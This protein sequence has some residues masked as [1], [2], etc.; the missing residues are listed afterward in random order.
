MQKILTKIYNKITNHAENV[1]YPYSTYG[2]LQLISNPIFYLTWLY[3]DKQGYES[4]PIRL[5]ISLF[6]IPLVFKEKW[7]KKFKRFIPL[8]W[9]IYALYSLPFFF[10]FMLLKNDLS[11]GWSLNSLTGVILTILLL[12]LISS[13][14]LV[15]LGI[16]L[17]LVAYYFTTENPFSVHADYTTVLITY[18]TVFIFGVLFAHKK[19]RLQ[20]AKL[21]ATKSIGASFAHEIRTP[22]AAIVMAAEAIKEYWS[23]ITEGY[24]LAK[25]H[26]LP[27]Q[28]LRDSQLNDLSTFVEDI[29]AETNY[30][31][32]IINMLL[33]KSNESALDSSELSLGSMQACVDESLRR[34]PFAPGE[35]DLV[36]WDDKSN[37]TFKGN[38]LFMTHVLFNLLKNAI[39]Y[40]RA[41]GKGNIHIWLEESRTVNKLYF[42]DTGTG[43]PPKYM[44]HLFNK[45]FTKTHGGTGLGL[46]FS[47]MVMQSFGGD[48]ICRSVEGEYT[49]FELSFPK[50]E[51]SL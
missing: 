34:Y 23:S 14:I 19:E 45:F 24:K 11:Y 13:A 50:I 2:L 5:G 16:S 4:L 29:L 41:A 44:K 35:R 30:A 15:P 20:Q 8:Y 18:S 43:I 37:F 3:F 9:Y 36:H 49:E 28:P 39:Y 32:T 12:D 27:V 10:T 33:V 47:K 40:V 46:A 1:A 21:A 22:L 31:N 6:C 26:H 25:Q 7:P 17:A 38:Q 42:K 48:I 51:A